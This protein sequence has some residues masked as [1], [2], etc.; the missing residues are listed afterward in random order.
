MTNLHLKTSQQFALVFMLPDYL[1]DLCQS[2]GMTLDRFNDES[3][4]RLPMPARYVIDQRR[5]IRGAEV[6]ADYTIRPDPSDTLRL[7]QTLTS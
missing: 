6:K 3:E 1:R 2:H 7:V 4:Y 5:T